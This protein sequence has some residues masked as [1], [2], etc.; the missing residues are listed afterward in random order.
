MDKYV[1]DSQILLDISKD[2]F[3]SNR[4]DMNQRSIANRS[5]I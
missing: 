2:V 1:Y 5:S 3:Y 4:K